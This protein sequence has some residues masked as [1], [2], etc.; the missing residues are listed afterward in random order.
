[1]NRQEA[2]GVHPAPSVAAAA[3]VTVH[4]KRSALPAAMQPP[5]ASLAIT[6]S[7]MGSPAT[8]WSAAGPAPPPPPGSR[9]AL[10]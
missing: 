8:A 9:G 3:G 7:S 6:A 10:C 2:D 1:M 4:L 5:R